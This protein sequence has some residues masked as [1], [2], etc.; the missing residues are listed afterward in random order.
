[1]VLDRLKKICLALEGA[2]CEQ[3]GSHAT[4]RAK[5][6]VFAYFL[7]NHHGDGIVAVACKV[8]PGDHEALVRAQPERFCKP[9]YIWSRGWV[10]LRLDRGK[11]DWDEVAE[12]VGE[13]YR[14]VTAKK[15][16]AA[17]GRR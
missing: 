13:S 5:K 11:V 12:F 16:L 6:K 2:E 17:D 9:A 1:M 3:S 15:K 7:D 4:F 10:S 8:A 14:L